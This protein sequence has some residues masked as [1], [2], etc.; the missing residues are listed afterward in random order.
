MPDTEENAGVIAINIFII[1]GIAV[2]II[3]VPGVLFAPRYLRYILMLAAVCTL[4]FLAYYNLSGA[5]LG[6]FVIFSDAV[7]APVSFTEHPYSRIAVFGFTLVGA[8]G[9]LYGLQLS[10]PSEQAAALLALAS[11]VGIVFCDNYIT[12]FI[13]WEML[14]LSTAALI[15]LRKTP[16]SLMAG[17]YFLS[18]HLAGGLVV[19]LGILLHYQA[20][21]SFALTQPQAGQVL[22]TIGFGFKAAFLPLHLWV[23]R[24]YPSANFPSSVLLAG[25]TT[26]IGV[27]AI[28][29]I[30]PASEVILLMGASMALVGVTCALL[31]HNM[32][33]LLS[34]HIISQVGYMVAGVGLATHY[35]VD[36]ALLHVVNHMLY[37]ALL[38]MSVGAAFYATGTE[39]LHDLLHEDSEEI[40]KL[41]KTIW[42][43]LPLVTLGAIVGA[44]AISGFPFF[45]G[46]VSKYLLKK[47]MYGAGPAETM[48]MIASI[49]TAASF[50]KLVVFGFIRGRAKI[51]NKVPVSSHLAIIGTATFC[52]LFGAYPQLVA[53]LLPYTTAVDNVYSYDGMWASMQLIIAG[54]LLFLNISAILK[55]GIHLPP[56]FSIEYLIFNPLGNLLFKRFCQYGSVIDSSVD[57]FYMKS[58]KS[59]YEFCRYITTLDKSVD[60][61]FEK[62]AQFGRSLADRTRYLDQ[63]IDDG[64][65]K[66]GDVA[67]RLANR[68][69]DLDR[70]LDESYHRAG[71]AARG[72]ANR[73]QDLDQALD[74]SYA[75]SGEMVR[76]VAAGAGE[77]SEGEER[78]KRRMPWN[79]V[80][81][82]TKNLNFDTLILA[83]LLG[84]ILVVIFYA[85]R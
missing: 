37:K 2:P 39:D 53:P 62:S 23:A 51:I 68:S 82:S 18:F 40:E 7:L 84:A 63:A 52:I 48:L 78:R 22:F 4:I 27:Y 24:G 55:R 11:V 79:P 54:S 28:A 43:A 67:R 75:R 12:L 20:S 41:K 26:K 70:A 31:Q 57:S 8:L 30:L 47:A 32:R 85:G 5:R 66:T 59:L 3:L 42:K 69:R 16:E 50:C 49:G 44:L 71:D 19:L 14:T 35:A 10:R 60:R 72:L 34:Y 80:E 61:A 9:L 58:G 65:S 25:L 83:L 21:G 17:L 38:F 56:V 36:G 46:Y 76:R 64:Y 74:E 6:T 15:L 33:R 73:S 13:F 77:G 45:N 81:W 29:R 1:A